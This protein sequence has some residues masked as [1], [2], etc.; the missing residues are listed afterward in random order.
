[1]LLPSTQAKTLKERDQQA[2][3]HPFTPLPD[4]DQVIS[5]T[6]AEGVYL[7]TSDGRKILDAISSWW[8]NLHGHSHP[9]IAEAVYKQATT[10]EHVIFAGFTH[11]PAVQLAERLLDTLPSNQD[12]I[13]YSD[14]GSTAVEVAL[15]MAFQYWYNQGISKKKVIALNGS[16]HGDTFG[17]MS[18][19]DRS[20]F[21]A[22]FNPYLFEV[23]FVDFPAC[24]KQDCCGGNSGETSV[25]PS[26]NEVIHSFTA[27]AESGEVAA[28]IYE[29][30]IQ[31]ASGMRMYAP[32]ILDTMLSVA[33][34]HNILC[35]ADEVMTGFGRTGRLFAS[36]YCR[37]LPDI[38]CL[39]KGLTGGTMALGVTS[40]T[41]E[42]MQ[43]YHSDDLMKTFFH[44]HSFTAN[45]L[46]CAAANASLDLLLTEDCQAN[47]RR[48]AA[49]HEKFMEQITA[50][51]A[52]EAMRCKGVI[53]AIEVKTGTE[54]SYFNEV[55][56]S[57]YTYFMERN[58]LL[59][60]LGNV[61]YILP[62]YVITND[63][64]DTIYAAIY[65]LL[66]KVR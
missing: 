62:P 46:A 25:C 24:Q 40:C 6:K 26:V 37:E 50:H 4:A 36:E 48:I 12:K 58:L 2:I 19:G 54:T 56:N 9:H 32:E 13:F 11:E 64:L 60:P 39:S 38:M 33:R 45:P 7:Y 61:V 16:Y 27:L 17:A 43:P 53:L 52:V 15:K 30:L 42:V 57:L 3:W 1:M 14:N 23:A 44:G 66:E 51:P 55:R 31:G 59:R 49:K 34:K 18:V 21:T 10:L 29:P 28:F 5:L 65:E 20:P 41:A 63:E 8:V 35:I 47:M 22:P